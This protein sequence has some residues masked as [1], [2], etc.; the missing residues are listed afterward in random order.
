[1]LGIYASNEHKVIF[2]EELIE[3]VIDFS[4]K[5]W[6]LMRDWNGVITPQLE[7]TSEKKIKITQFFFKKKMNN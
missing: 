7:R 4:Y 5:N 3:R 1:M 2:Y 6:S